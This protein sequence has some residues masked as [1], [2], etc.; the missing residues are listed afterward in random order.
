RGAR[1]AIVARVR[2]GRALAGAEL[3]VIVVGARIEVVA[4]RAVELDEAA[5]R[6]A[7]A[8]IVGARVAVVA[9][10]WRAAAARA[11]GTGAPHDA[12]VPWDERRVFVGVAADERAARRVAVVIGAAVAV[13]A[14]AG[15]GGRAA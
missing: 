15:A 3:A 5:A 11:L 7:V 9:A 4:G 6:R 1:I 13:V 8:E 10:A 2:V 12:A 14:H